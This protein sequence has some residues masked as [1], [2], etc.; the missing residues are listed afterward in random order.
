MYNNDLPRRADLPS[1]AQLARSTFIA[2]V[3]A[4]VILLVFVLPSEYGIDPFRIGR[5]LGLTE[6]GKIK[7]QLAEEAAADLAG[8]QQAAAAAVAP[9]EAT[10]TASVEPTNRSDEISFTLAPDEGIEVKL[11]MRAGARA[12]YSWTTSG[13]A[14]NC[15]THADA[16]G[17]SK[18]YKQARGIVG[19]EGVLQADFEGNHGWFWR[20]RSGGDVTITLRTSGDYLELKRKI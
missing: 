5:L 18:T 11:V 10:T 9:A 12:S 16:P 6:M 14:V 17:K 3:S 2:F 15:D 19:D 20:N 4:I 8:Q 13:P 1:S 7:V